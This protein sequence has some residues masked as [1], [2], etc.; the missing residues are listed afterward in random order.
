MRVLI[1]SAEIIDPSS[2]FHGQKKDV[3][4]EDG[5]IS[6]IADRIDQEADHIFE[7][8]GLYL[9]VGWFDMRV[10][11]KDPGQEHK[12]DLQS[13]SR[14]ASA[15]GFTEIAVLP[16]THP[17]V[18]TKEGVVYQLRAGERGAVRIHPIAAVTLKNEG[19][20][21]AEMIDLHMAGAVAFSDGEHPI[22]HADIFVK[23]LQ[24]LQPFGGLLINRPK[25]R[26]FPGLEP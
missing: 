9:S 5:K 25:I 14:A 17:T 1:H 21:L 11:S 26:C 10:S 2:P 13:V 3:W 20:E 12:E 24:Y 4:V 22:W 19:K 23:T 18:Q 8:A 6:Q 16:D 7:A 15:G